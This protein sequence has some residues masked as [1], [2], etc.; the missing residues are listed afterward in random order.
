MQLMVKAEVVDCLQAK[1]ER[2]MLMMR[3]A[4]LT[5]MNIRMNFFDFLHKKRDSASAIKIF[6]RF[7]DR[8]PQRQSRSSTV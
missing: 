5:K 3:E 8:K 4:I 7:V 2:K 1:L 6:E